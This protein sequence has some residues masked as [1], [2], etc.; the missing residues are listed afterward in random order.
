MNLTLLTWPTQDS[1]HV[2]STQWGV[3]ILVKAAF[4]PI[5]G[6]NTRI[7]PLHTYYNLYLTWSC[8]SFLQRNENWNKSMSRKKN[9]SSVIYQFRVLHNVECYENNELGRCGNNLN[10]TYSSVLLEWLRKAM[11]NFSWSLPVYGL[12]YERGRFRIINRT[13]DRQ[14]A[15]FSLWQ[16]KWN[17]TEG[18]NTRTSSK[19]YEANKNKRYEGEMQWKTHK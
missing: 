18:V 10:V 5:L 1:S 8:L 4:N 15:I 19:K 2:H 11:K 7:W 6:V 16:M 12:K 17:K 13:A 9:V 14:T 3:F